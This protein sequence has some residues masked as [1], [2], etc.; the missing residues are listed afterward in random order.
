MSETETLPFPPRTA[1]EPVRPSLLERFFKLRAHGT[2]ARTEIVAGLT[3]F[4]TMAYVLAVNPMILHDAGMPLAPLITVTAISAATSCLAMGLLTNYPLALAPYM[5]SNAYFTYQICLGMKIPWEAAL[6]FTFYNAVLFFIL[7]GTGVR[8][9]FIRAFPPYLRAGITAGVGLFI[10]FIGLRNAGVIVADKATMVALGPVSSPGCLIALAGV[11]MISLLLLWGVRS[12]IIV[13]VAV[14]TGL[15]LFFHGA[16]G[17]TLTPMPTGI[18]SLPASMGPVLFHLDLAYPFH[19]FQQ[20]FPVILALLFTDYFCCFAS[21]IA[22]C[23]RAGLLDENGSMPR[24]R[25]VLCVDAGVAG[26]GALLGTSTTGVY[27]ESAAGVEQGGRTGLT[28]VITGL[29]FFAAMFFNPLIQIIPAVATAPALII[30]GIFMMQELTK[31]NFSDLAQ[32]TPAILTVVLMPLA[33]ISDGIAIGF[34]AHVAI[35]A[36]TGKFRQLPVFSLLLA[37][38]FLVHYLLET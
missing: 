3:I 35:Q 27:I 4:A 2:T 1:A 38:L 25:S 23:Q 15:G 10:A 8:E 17:H 14:L 7:A 37:A 31:Q 12:A 22:T 21:Q 13:T 29:C 30:I 26:V 28:V 34:L 24:M 18:L 5:G 11:L 20:S 16:D 6:G 32:A 36:G 19:H 9:M 33:T